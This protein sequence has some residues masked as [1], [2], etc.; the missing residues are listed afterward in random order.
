MILYRLDSACKFASTQRA[1]YCTV[2]ACRASRLCPAREL[3]F[4]VQ[5]QKSCG[6]QKWVEEMAPYVKSLDPNHLLTLGEEGFYSTSTRRLSSNPGAES[7]SHI[8]QLFDFS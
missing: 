8:M 4:V 2:A 5:I 3:S 6:V 7:R 1:Q